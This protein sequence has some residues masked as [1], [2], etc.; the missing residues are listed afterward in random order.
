MFF[1]SPFIE[2][3]TSSRKSFESAAP[4]SVTSE[5]RNVFP[6]IC[7]FIDHLFS[8][9]MIIVPKAHVRG[10]FKWFCHRFAS[11]GVRLALLGIAWQI[12]RR[13]EKP[14]GSGSKIL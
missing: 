2:L 8:N 5:I 7:I 1:K 12:E 6:S 9:G 4:N 10:V 13:C 14:F 3:R 11:E